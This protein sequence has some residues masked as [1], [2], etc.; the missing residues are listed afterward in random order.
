MAFYE[1]E[2][3]VKYLLTQKRNNFKSGFSLGT[4]TLFL[5]F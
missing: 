4:Q 1:Y 2:I 3:I 5:L